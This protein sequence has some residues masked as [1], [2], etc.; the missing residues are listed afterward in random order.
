MYDKGILS[1]KVANTIKEMII[2]K[3]LNPG[4]KLANELELTSE[5]NVSPLYS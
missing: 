4:D 1:E 3:K 5:L 2:N